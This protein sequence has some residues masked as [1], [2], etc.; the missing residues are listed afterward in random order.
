MLR[1]SR[2]IGLGAMSHT[3]PSAV[4]VQHRTVHNSESTAG[5]GGQIYGPEHAQ[6]QVTHTTVL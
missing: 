2:K 4:S 1:S 3:A 5:L 6:L